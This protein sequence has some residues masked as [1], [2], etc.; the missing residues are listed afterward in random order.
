M[1]NELHF[2]PHYGIVPQ[3]DHQIG[4][5]TRILELL[6]YRETAT[7]ASL[8]LE[9]IFWMRERAIVSGRSGIEQ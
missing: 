7:S 8:F 9:H 6:Q 1:Q 5:M 4:R 3:S 2:A